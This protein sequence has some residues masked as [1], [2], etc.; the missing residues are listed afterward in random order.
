[1]ARV[2]SLSELAIRTLMLFMLIV[3][4]ICGVRREVIIIWKRVFAGMTNVLSLYPILK[5]ITLE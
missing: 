5:L 3:D 4:G 1:V 2:D